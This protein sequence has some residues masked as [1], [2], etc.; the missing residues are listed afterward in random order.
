M[1]FDREQFLY[2][3][4]NACMYSGT[5]IKTYSCIYV[6]TQITD[7]TWSPLDLFKEG[8]VIL[9]AI[10]KRLA[11]MIYLAKVNCMRVTLLQCS[12]HSLTLNK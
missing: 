2:L 6:G 5:L 8:F 10:A 3:Y 12:K 4:D 9:F 1:H 11:Y 7:V